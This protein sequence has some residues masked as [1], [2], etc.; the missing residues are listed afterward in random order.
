[1]SYVE[2]KT[3]TTDTQRVAVAFLFAIETAMR[4]GEIANLRTKDVNF[5]DRVALLR[6]TKNGKDRE[7]P[8]SSRAIKLLRVLPKSSNDT[9]FDLSDRSGRSLGDRL[10]YLFAK[11]K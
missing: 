6:L 9:I 5:E 4:A 2:G 1:M 3:P 7:V 8:L 10:S 11:A